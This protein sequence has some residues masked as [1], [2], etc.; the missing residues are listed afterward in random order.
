MDRLHETGLD[1]RDHRRVGIERPVRAD[2]APETEPLGI[3]GQQQF[4]GRHGVADSV[5]ERL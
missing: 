1:R 4:D 3:G 5:I 2:L